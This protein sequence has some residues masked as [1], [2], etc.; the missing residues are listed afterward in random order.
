GPRQY[1]RRRPPERVTDQQQSPG[2]TVPGLSHF[3][4]CQ[5][6]SDLPNNVS[7]IP[8]TSFFAPEL[9]L[10]FH[11]KTLVLLPALSTSR[12]AAGGFWPGWSIITAGWL[13]PD[14]FSLSSNSSFLSLIR[15]GFVSLS[16]GISRQNSLYGAVPMWS[17][18]SGWKPMR[19][20]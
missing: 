6:A 18:S 12:G 19:S 2:P 5:A 8:R 13:L 14:A 7:P 16:A 1:C 15:S 17:P 3:S 11:S 9:R 10:I 20:V 4:A